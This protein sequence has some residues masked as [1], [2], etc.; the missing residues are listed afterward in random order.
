V[1]AALTPHELA[2]AIDT[3][4]AY[5]CELK[6]PRQAKNFQSSDLL[7]VDIDGGR[8][9][10]E[11]LE[12]PLAREHLTVLYT[13]PSHTEEEH[14][15]RLIFASPRTIEDPAEMKAAM[16]SL[17]L[18]LNGDLTATDAARLFYGS[19]GSRPR[20]WDRGLSEQVL[21]E[22]IEQG[23]D[24]AHMGDGGQAPNTTASRL[25][26]HPDQ[27]LRTADGLLASVADLAPGTAICCPFHHDTNPSAFVVKSSTGVS[28]G[29]HC[30]ACVQ[31]F[32]LAGTSFTHDFFEF[33]RAVEQARVEFDRHRDWGP[34]APF[35]ESQEHFIRKGL[36][37]A[38]ISFQD[39][40]YL[41]LD[42]IEEGLTFVKSPKGTGKTESLSRA[43]ASTTGLSGTVLLIGHRIAL[44]RQ[45]CGRLGL[46]CYLDFQGK[47]QR[48][49]LGICWDSLHRLEKPG[50]LA[51]YQTIIIDESEQVLA[52]CLSDTIASELRD[53]NF[54]ILEALFKGTKRVKQKLVGGAKRVVALD[55]DLGF[56]T[57]ATLTRLANGRDG[58]S[59]R[60][61]TSH[62]IINRHKQAG[63]IQILDS[64]EHLIADLHESLRAGKRVFVVS[65]ARGRINA[66]AAGL[67]SAFGSSIR[68]LRITS[69]TN[70]SDD[71]V[72]FIGSP[73]TEALE[74]N[75][76][77]ASPTIG[78]GIDVSFK[79]G[80]SRVDVVYGFFKDGITTHFDMD[81]QL[82]R[83]RNPGEVKVW[84]SPKRFRFDTAIDVV[85]SDIH[86][87]NLFK[88]VLLRYED[89]RPVYDMDD[90]LI[91][92]ASLI[93]SRERASKN[94]LKRH[95][96]EHKEHQGYKVE[97]VGK[98][99]RLAGEGAVVDRLG[100]ELSEQKRIDAL[101]A[102]APLPYPEFRD[103]EERIRR[104][105]EVS[106]AE[107]WS[108]ARRK[109]ERF[110]RAPIS[111]DL[112]RLDAEGRYR[113]CVW[114]FERV[115][116]ALEPSDWSE[117]RKSLT[118][119]ST[120]PALAS[121]FVRSD[122]E[123]V[124]TIVHLL[125][126]TPLLIHG[127]FDPEAVVATDDLRGFAEETVR[128][129]HNVET[130]LKIEVRRDVQAKPT[131]QLNAI[132]KKIGL[133]CVEVG[134]TRAKA[135]A[136]GRAV[137]HYRLDRGALERM[138]ELVVLR[139]ERDPW[140][141][142]YEIHGWDLQDLEDANCDD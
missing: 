91:E 5:S 27:L 55:A 39:E 44:I 90:P 122:R 106:E 94:N 47:L 1:N 77:L 14:R 127:R 75:V 48:P 92:M 52:H 46:D 141:T 111:P 72:R 128:L 87:Q 16:R 81:Q 7:S 45:S 71:V 30:S 102:A 79:D 31:T 117:F 12:D 15:F 13:T 43:L 136:D 138:T 74:Y 142:L 131:S 95:F 97:I 134:K 89:G 23:L 105:G 33:D 124:D 109:I 57:F 11:V 50:D 3:G 118:D 116:R 135:V 139:K 34:L 17:A 2:R 9:I 70:T 125:G 35:L 120:A 59:G 26:L 121:R 29:I 129:K 63:R 137:R 65:N 8:R 38:N 85:R 114:L 132:L 20:V 61:R 126:L 80:A 93:V 76:I 140:V 28:K 88:S 32:W 123:A 41:R 25:S 24:A 115:L 82:G 103:I 18:R 58:G 108:R 112:I 78:T 67:E 6:G 66:L 73:S 101:M 68:L 49:Q 98:D 10:E 62:V 133:R 119:A 96:I 60:L 107:Q 22:L 64:R 56:A 110:Y 83:V 21:D 40:R 4:V 42:R 99:V 104:N 69:E 37:Q 54:K 84:V 86:R 130:Q 113:G 51:S 19:R 36:E 53:R 100:R